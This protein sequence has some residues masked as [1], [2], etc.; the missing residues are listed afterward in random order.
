MSGFFRFTSS[1][2]A[3][4]IEVTFRDA[5][6]HPVNLAPYTPRIRFRVRP[7]GTRL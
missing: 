2:S 3:Q 7:G 6:G 1:D 4:K 5:F